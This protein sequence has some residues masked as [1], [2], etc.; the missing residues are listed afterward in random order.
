M[1]SSSELKVGTGPGGNPRGFLSEELRVESL[2]FALRAG[3]ELKVE[4]L[5]SDELRVE[6]LEFALRADR[7]PREWPGGEG[8]EIDVDVRKRRV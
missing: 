1:V 7:G 4:S 6:S 5:W 2:W 3:E 8:E